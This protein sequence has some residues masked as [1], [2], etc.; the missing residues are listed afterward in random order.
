MILEG[1]IKEAKNE[2]SRPYSYTVWAIF[3]SMRLWSFFFF[4]FVKIT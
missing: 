3:L 1:E 2:D 4:W